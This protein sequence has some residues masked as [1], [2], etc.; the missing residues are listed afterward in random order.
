MLQPDI[1]DAL[2]RLSQSCVS[3]APRARLSPHLATGLDIARAVA[4][5][6]VVLHHVAV[7][8]AWQTIPH[9]GVLFKFGQEAV[10]AFFLLSGVVIFANER[11]RALRPMGYALRRLR[12]IYPGLICALIVSTLVALDNHTLGASFHVTELA[13]TLLNLQDLPG[14]KP[15]VIVAP[16]LDND[17]LW[18]LS[19]EVAFYAA[20]PF[21]LRAWRRAPRLTNHAVG[22]VCCLAYAAYVAHPN[23][24]CLITAYFLTWW[25]G[26]MAANAYLS[27]ETSFLAI[28]P[29]L[30]WLVALA[31]IAAFAIPIVGDGSLYEYPVLPL[32]HFG[33]A[34]IA[35]VTL[36]GPAGRV[37]VGV[38]ARLAPA[39]AAGASVSYGVYILHKPLLVQSQY[40]ATLPGL[41][42]MLLVLLVLATLVDTGLNRVL[43]RAPRD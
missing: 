23:H 6:Y 29:S 34:L 2:N 19:Y 36:F 14:L 21:V 4:A 5:F 37:L 17:P 38:C 30:P 1:G 24:W 3:Q 10:I 32:R 39:A 43:P 11:T 13:G 42:G 33:V 15:G 41:G 18:S 9:W 27:G 35:L 25:A 16:Y 8:R 40:A 22:A 20:F 31:G 28:G 26:A 12:R 7:A